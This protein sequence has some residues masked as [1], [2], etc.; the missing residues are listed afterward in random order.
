M[1]A[2]IDGLTLGLLRCWADAQPDTAVVSV[3]TLRAV[4]ETAV[5]LRRQL[6]DATASEHA[7]WALLM[8][9]LT[10]DADPLT[11]CPKDT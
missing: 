10:A 2:P 9:D 5:T 1:T 6:R 8:A 4:L 7:A 3:T 11:D